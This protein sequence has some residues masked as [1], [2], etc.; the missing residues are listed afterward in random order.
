MKSFQ[1]YI[2]SLLLFATSILQGQIISHKYTQNRS[3][4]VDEATDA[5]RQLQK[6][7]PKICTLQEVGIS[8]IGRPI[9]LFIIS[10]DG[11]FSPEVAKNKGKL[12]LFVNNGI[13]GG[14]PPGVDASI[15]FA[16]EILSKPEYKKI[17]KDIVVCIIP[18]YNVDGGLNRSCC[19]RTNQNGP[20]EYGFRGN[21]QNRDLNRDFIKTDTR[22]TE[23]FVA[24]F[25]S[26]L[27]DVFIDTHDTNGSDF[28]YVMTL[29]T[30]QLDKQNR[31]L[32]DYQ[33]KSYLPKLYEDM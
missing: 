10:E 21:A 25:Q 7:Y 5:Y 31:Y 18:F 22:N 29:I 19:S 8:D 1:I 30:S 6:N 2:A 17:L 15:K 13:H 4:T 33:R 9:H 11:N 28:Q 12:V 26:W 16:E 27:P 23:A 20:E 24:A 3:F 32:A 14:E